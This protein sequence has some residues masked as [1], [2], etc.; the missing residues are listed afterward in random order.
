[1]SCDWDPATVY[2]SVKRKARKSHTCCECRGKIAVGETYELVTGLWEGSWSTFKTCP[3]CLPVR[4]ALAATEDSCGGYLHGGLREE[5]CN[6]A[7]SSDG[8]RLIGMYNASVA[9]RGGRR[10]EF[11]IVGD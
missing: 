11:T 9:H 6:Y 2:V 1:M 8:P 5:L 3:D 7:P 10:V 4:C